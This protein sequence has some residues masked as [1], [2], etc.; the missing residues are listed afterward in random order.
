MS[1]N[2]F[3]IINQKKLKIENRKKEVENQVYESSEKNHRFFLVYIFLL[4]YVLIIVSSTTD[5][6]L[7]LEERGIIL[8]LLN[9]HVSLVGFYI[10]APLLILFIH[11]NLILHS[12]ITCRKLRNLKGIYN[13]L[14]PDIKIKN[15]ILDIAILSNNNFHSKT[16]KAL[17]N[18]LYICSPYCIISD[19]F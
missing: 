3:D 5:L 18:I 12:S 4:T 19:F 9:I 1:A 13:N 17:A 2:G 7:L 8:P 16:Y 6:Q 10:I 14:V 11:V 15:N